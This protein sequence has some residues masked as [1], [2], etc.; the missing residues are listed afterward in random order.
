M[1]EWVLAHTEQYK[2]LKNKAVLVSGKTHGIFAVPRRENTSGIID[3]EM[4]VL[5]CFFN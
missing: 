3:N 2:F 4:I 5:V 1:N